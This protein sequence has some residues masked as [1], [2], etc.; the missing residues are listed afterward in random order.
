MD[1]DRQANEETK[2]PIAL[3]SAQPAADVSTAKPR[4]IP[5]DLGEGFDDAWDRLRSGFELSPLYDHPE[6]LRRLARYTDNQSYFDTVAARAA[7]FLV[8]LIEIVEQRALPLELALVPFV[9]SA[10]DP[11]ARSSQRAVG[12]WQFMPAT[13]KSFGLTQD[14]WIDER[15]DPLLS[16]HAALD[17]LAALYEEFD[18]DWLLALAA[19][20]AGGGNVRRAMKHN[21]RSDDAQD[22]TGATPGDGSSQSL[23]WSLRLTGETRAHV[24]RILALAK[25][26]QSP[27]DYGITLPPIPNATQMSRVPLERQID[28]ARAAEF[29]D[30]EL[31]T[32]LAYNP[33]FLQWATPPREG[34]SLLLTADAA[35]NF[36]RNVDAHRA[37][38]FVSYDRVL[39]RRG[40]TLS[41]IARR[42]GTRVDILQRVNGLKDSRIVAG[43]SLLVP[44]GSLDLLT[45]QLPRIAQQASKEARR[46]APANYT[47]RK[48]DN[49]WSIAR[50][51]DLRSEDIRTIN[52]LDEDSLLMPGQRLQLL[53]SIDAAALATD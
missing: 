1:S 33:Q 28:L 38:S 31:A 7:P 26:I 48:G 17:Y 45:Q 39:I 27:S 5:E 9:E 23:F 8:D 41:A 29:A 12:L 37:D 14:W 49:L 50:R 53:P 40:D 13:G 24:P 16:T 15:R 4:P 47:V 46:K 11:A 52:G 34:Q 35:Q 36:L 21:T 22:S 10:F 25:V 32:L 20:N 30:L 51:Y 44:Q 6:V 18:R 2:Q 3:E 42:L 19:Y 43:R